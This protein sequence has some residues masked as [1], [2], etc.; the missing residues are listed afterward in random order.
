[1]FSNLICI[2]LFSGFLKSQ[3]KIT[4]LAEDGLLITADLYEINPKK[5]YILLFH[6]A[7]YSRGE[8]KETT[9]KFQINTW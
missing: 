4:F 5:P 9:Q 6:Q 8:Y 2:L 3:E 1:M 7:G